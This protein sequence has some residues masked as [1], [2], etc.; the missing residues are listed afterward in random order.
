MVLDIIPKLL[1]GGMSGIRESF[2]TQSKKIRGYCYYDWGKSAFETSVTVAILPAWFTYLFLEANGLT[3]TI[4][5]IEMTADAVWSLSVAIATLLVAVFSPPFGVIADRRLIKIKWLKILTYVGAGATFLLAFAPLFPVSFQW[6]WLMIMFL[7]ANIGLNGAGVFYNALLPHMGEEDEMDDISNRAFAFG[8]FG[9]GILLVI[10]LGLVMGVGTDNDWVIPFC[11][12]T[13]GIWWY[14]FALLTFLWV[15]EPP[16]ENEMEKLKFLK[17]ARFAIKEVGQTL[18]DIKRFPSLFLYMLA[19]FFFIDGINTVTALGGVFGIAVLGVTTTQLIIT[20]LAIQFVAA[21][22][23]LAFTKL[24]EKIGTKKALSFS[25]MGWVFLCF[26]A[27]SFAPLE[28]EDHDEFFIL[29]EWDESEEVYVVH[30]DYDTPGIAQKLVYEDNEFDEQAWAEE[31]KDFLPL[32][33]SSK[34]KTQSWNYGDYDDNDEWVN[35]TKNLTGVTNAEIET[36]LESLDETRFSA[37]VLG[38]SLN[39]NKKVGID[40]PTDLSDGPIDFIPKWARDNIWSWLNFT[41]FFQFLLLGCMMGTLLGGSQGLA[42]SIFGQ[43]I[44]ETRSTEFFG[45]FG[46]FGKVAA[47]MGPFIYFGMTTAFDSRVGILSISVIILIGAV[48]LY[49]VDIEA[50]REDARA[51]DKLLREA[52]AKSLESEQNQE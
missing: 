27:L 7:F 37:S 1:S 15:P 18:R 21:P 31:W 43:I 28:L 25:I 29:Y 35:F 2:K 51:E 39:G 6:I 32:E 36:F 5:S 30:V 12:A 16:I 50:G 48:L 24:A 8:Y 33:Y 26:A 38:G 45:F 22:S 13:S 11:M 14:G 17:A 42:R 52:V 40:H 19:Y 47:F 9:G 4:G 44:P 10:H 34:T 3:T 46:F 49:F 23:A 20:I 41:V